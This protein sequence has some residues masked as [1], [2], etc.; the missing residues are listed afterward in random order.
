MVG[1]S[2]CAHAPQRSTRVK[3]DNEEQPG[4]IADACQ[5][6]PAYRLLDHE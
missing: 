2:L 6:D 1:R 5:S 4:T 3:A